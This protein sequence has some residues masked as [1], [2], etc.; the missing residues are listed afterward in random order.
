MKHKVSNIHT[1]LDEISIPYLKN[2]VVTFSAGQIAHYIENWRK[3]TSDPYILN[4]VSGDTIDFVRHPPFQQ[5]YPPNGIS[6]DLL[7]AIKSELRD[8]LSKGVVIPVEHE[9]FEFVSSIFC[10]P[11]KDDRVRLIL[12]LKKLNSFVAYHHFKMETIQHIL[13]MVTPNCW[14]ASVNLK[15]AYYSVKVH[16]SY[17]RYLKFKFQGE[18]YAYTVYPNGLASCPRQFTKLLKPPISLLRSRG[19]IL[20]S[21]IDDIYIQSDT[22][23][24]CIDSVLST[25]QE[26][27][28]LGFVIHPEKS[29]FIPKQ[30]IQYLGFILD[31][32][33]MRITLPAKRKQKLKDSLSLICAH[34]SNVRIRDVAKAVGYMV[35]SL[36]AVPFGGIYYRKL[37][38]EKI[39]ALKSANGNFDATMTVNAPA[40]AELKWWLKNVD[41]SYGFIR[42]SP[43][44]VTIYSDASP[45]GWGAVLNNVST[46]GKWF[47]SELSYHI[48]VR[49]LLAAYF[50]LKSFKSDVE[51]KHIKLM[52]DNTT[53]VAAINHMGTNHSNECNAIA[54]K[55]WSFCFK[56]SIWL[57]ACH[58][59]GK[60]NVVADRESRQF[61]KQDA[62]WMLNKDILNKALGRLK[63][64]PEI[65]LF[66]SRLNHQFAKY[67]SLRPDPNAMI[68]NAF[69][70]SWNGKKFY[71]FPPFS[72]IL[73]ALQKIQQDKAIGI[74]VVPNWPTQPWFPI[75]TKMLQAPPVHLRA[76][77]TLLKLP[78][79]PHQEHPL[80]P[81]LKLMVCLVSGKF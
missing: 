59:P 15:D 8:L 26:F 57:T 28:S 2:R 50:A 79:M 33:S 52:V 39:N 36:P 72:C 43:P 17:Q 19:H 70:F 61:S 40:L 7:S 42:L 65:D 68:I 74:L 58:I 67:C 63:F 56:Y 38:N 62:E 81:K 4:I 29:E 66:A 73:P 69:T 37:E 24:G 45:L 64:Y 55:I 14:M 34:P 21:Y 78:S 35:S 76:K 77:K 27:D 32:T 3:I 44:E 11:K 25:F 54:I 75:L 51:N 80:L 46:N 47:P 23:S 30:R 6:G 41:K 60:S 49:E 12:N 16:P 10:V 71:C 22:Y 9:D 1:F 53:A 13:S 20:S 48:N 5:S 31:S 18:L